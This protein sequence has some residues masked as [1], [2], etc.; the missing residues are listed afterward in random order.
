MTRRAMD[1]MTEAGDAP[2]CLHLSYIKPHWPYIAPAPY[3]TM[4]GADD[5]LPVVRSE[6]E[7]RDAHPVYRAFMDL[8]VSS[9]FARDEVRTEVIPV[10]MGLIRQIDDQLGALFRFMS[11]RGLMDN[12]LIVFTS[13]HG[14][15]LGDHWM[16]EKDLFHDPSVKVPLI[17]FDP[18]EAADAARGTACD[19]LV[20]TIDL[21][22]TFL[23]A[24]GADPAEQ[25]H[26]L[27]GRSLVSFLHGAAPADWR[28]F[29]FS[30]YDYSI[31]PVAAKLGIEPCNARLFMVTDGRWKYVHA[32][33]F[34]PMLYD[35]ESDPS[36]FN[37]LGADPAREAECQRLAAAL[38]EW[39]LRQSQRTTRS[40]QQ[41]KAAR[42]KSQRKGILIGVWDEADVAAELWSKYLGDET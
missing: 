19:V 34:R 37:D 24:L 18:S 28:R 4:Y 15:Y 38:A 36:E 40:E 6:H 29:A 20:E 32:V 23:Q 1:F 17:V 7:R 42:G 41:M 13:D 12:T 33:G 5:V 9:T 22:P 27:E 3:N 31:L 2:W 30:E 11:T 14:D 26:R 21:V 35:L 39:G 25:S 10:Y 8:R 16:G